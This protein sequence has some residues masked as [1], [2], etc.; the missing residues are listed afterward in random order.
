MVT[1]PGGGDQATVPCTAPSGCSVKGC[2]AAVETVWDIVVWMFILGD[3]GFW[4]D[5]TIIWRSGL[6]Y[7]VFL[8]LGDFL[9]HFGSIDSDLSWAFLLFAG[10]ATMDFTHFGGIVL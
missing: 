10:L 8:S 5:D 9:V 3:A 4:S 1:G 2:M 7:S 6:P